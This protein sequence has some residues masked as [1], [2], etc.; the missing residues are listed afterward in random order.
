[1][2]I[3]S[4]TVIAQAIGLFL[5]PILTRLY[6][7][8]V[9]GEFSVYYRVVTFIATVATARYELSIPLPKSD[10]HSFQIF[11]M[12]L[13]I[14]LV[15]TLITFF[16]VLV[17]ILMNQLD[18]SSVVI[19]LCVI[20]GTFFLVFFNLGTNWAIRKKAFRHISF[21]KIANSGVMNILRVG[22]GFF[23]P[24]VFSL[25]L[26]FI[27]S[28]AIGSI[29]FLKDFL[30]NAKLAVNRRSTKK[31]RVLAK[32]YID[33]PRINLPHALTDAARDVIVAMLVVEY[34]S[35]EI[36]GSFDHSLRMLRLPLM[37]IGAA[38]GQVFY[39]KATELKNQ[40]K[41]MLP[42][43]QKTFFI[44]TWL[45][46]LPFMVIFFWGESIF[47]FVFGSN[48]AQSGRISEV[49]APWLMLNFITSPFT[50]LPLVFN[51]QKRF[52]FIGLGSS[53]LQIICFSV[54]PFWMGTGDQSL[55]QIFWILSVT[56]ILTLIY[57]AQFIRSI[58]RK[59]D[60]SLVSVS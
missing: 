59:W 53:L 18:T 13:R 15:T 1:M 51:E 47:A 43:V 14:A 7:P 27:V 31:M 60:R 23:A 41:P 44:L 10:H 8:E 20:A 38:I 37:L 46:V 28:L 3:A 25:V 4:G 56:Q 55:I 45:S 11:R 24:N 30:S 2:V 57:T 6:T 33:F 29:F 32:T 21:S 34:F 35:T 22:F 36:F 40:N 16:G 9:M 26:S 50:F 49:M 5:A 54:L 42:F 52:F 58:V 19:G 48:W 39:N 12:S 17:Y